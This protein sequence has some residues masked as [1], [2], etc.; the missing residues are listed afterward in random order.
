MQYFSSACIYNTECKKQNSLITFFSYLDLTKRGKK[1]QKRMRTQRHILFLFSTKPKQ[2]YLQFF[3]I[4]ASTLG[5]P[6]SLA[7]A[8]LSQAAAFCFICIWAMPIRR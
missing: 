7:L 4:R 5:S 6:S 1:T 2:N 3:S 8:K